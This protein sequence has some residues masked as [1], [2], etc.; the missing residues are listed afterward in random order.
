MQLNHRF[1]EF[2]DLTASGDLILFWET[3]NDTADEFG[4]ISGTVEIVDISFNNSGFIDQVE[5]KFNNVNVHQSPTSSLCVND[6]YVYY[7]IY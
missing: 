1:Q 2:Y 3:G 5:M 4:S 7:N 6:G